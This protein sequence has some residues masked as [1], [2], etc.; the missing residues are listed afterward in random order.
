MQFA[1]TILAFAAAAVAAPSSQCTFGQYSC[2]PDGKS[3]L[4]CDISGHLVT[5]GPCPD[6][7]KCSPIGSIPYCQAT[8]KAKR[9]GG[10][11]YCAAPGTYTCSGNTDIYVCNAQN[12]LIF[13]GHCPENTHCG[14]I[15]EIPFCLDN[16]VHM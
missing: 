13:N 7:S 10:P 3:I 1:A 11:E 2:S 14:Y 16:A 12:Q 6:G 9:A 15:G 4:Q 8:P 5:I